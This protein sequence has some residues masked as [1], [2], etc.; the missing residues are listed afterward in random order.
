MSVLEARGLGVRFGDVAALDGVDLAVADGEF[1]AVVGP[2]GC[3]K[4]TLLRALGGLLPP[5]AAVSG[6]LALPTLPDGGAALGVPAKSRSGATASWGGGGGPVTAWMPQRDGL[7]PWR[8]AWS[9]ALLGA[10]IARIPRPDAEARAAE[11]FETFGLSGFERAWPHELSGGMR[12]RLALLRTC[13]AGR[14]VLLLDEPFG[15]LDPITRRRMNEWLAG[16]GLVGVGP[17]GDLPGEPAASAGPAVGQRAVVLVT[18]DVD[19]ALALADRVVVLSARPGRVVL[20][21][22][23]PTR[24]EVLAALEY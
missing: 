22:A 6:T 13:L 18:H 21:T 19:E 24:D 8:R 2:S 4:S 5:G 3:G 23:D 15:A 20:D 10:R 1:V 14:P 11:L 17:A 9:N 16:V 7:L 12:Q